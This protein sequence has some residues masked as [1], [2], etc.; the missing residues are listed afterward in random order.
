MSTAEVSGLNA[1]VLVLNRHYMAV[2]VVNVRRAF[3]LLVNRLADIFPD[4]SHVQLVGLDCSDDEQVW[5][6]AKL[7]GFIIVTKDVD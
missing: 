3:G 1:S 4:S 2:H 6:H 5:E 7:N